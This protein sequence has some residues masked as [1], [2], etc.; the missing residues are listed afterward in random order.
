[1]Q[2]A[3]EAV[4]T[5]PFVFIESPDPV[6]FGLVESLAAPGGQRHRAVSLRRSLAA[7]RLE[8]LKEV[9]PAASRIAFLWLAGSLTAPHQLQETQAAAPGLG[10]TLLPFA[11][12]P[13]P[14][15]VDHAALTAMAQ[16]QVEALYVH[17]TVTSTAYG[18]SRM[19]ELAGAARSRPSCTLWQ[20]VEA[21]GLMSYGTHFPDLWRR[22][23]GVV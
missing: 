17:P 19:V 9:V 7:K 12:G 6:G 22:A 16:A 3:K 8:L 4:T 15:D 23:A 10:V 2:V 5:I 18:R 21:G 14:D 1:M 20:V 11:V 13:G